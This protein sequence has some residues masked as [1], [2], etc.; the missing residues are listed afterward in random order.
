MKEST[1]VTLGD[2]CTIDAK[3]VDPREAQYALLPHI[4]GENIEA[5]TR[6]LVNV[7]RVGKADLISGK[8]LFSQGDVLYSKLRPYLQ[9]VCVAPERGLC[10]A[11]MY[12][13]R[14]DHHRLVAEY[15]S[16]LLLSPQFTK[17]A[18]TESARARMPKLNRDQLL[19]YRFQLPPLPVQ[20]RIAAKLEAGMGAAARARTAAQVRYAAATALP[21][22]MFRQVFHDI[23]P[24][25]TESSPSASPSRR[26]WKLLTDIARLESGH[27]PS[28][29]HPEW[30]GGDIPWLALPDIRQL[31]GNVAMDTAEHTNQAGLDNSSARLLPENTVALSRTASVG[32]VTIFGKPMATSQDFVNWV[33]GP[34]LR[35]RFLFHA[36]RASRGYLRSLASGAVHK[37]IYMPTVQALRVCVPTLE[38]Q[39]SI[40]SILDSSLRQAEAISKTLDQELE[41]IAAIPATLL[42]LAFK[43]QYGT[44]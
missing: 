43:E 9:K 35:P 29:R 1:T 26:T 17:Y 41:T 5:G 15:L 36:L 33:C 40:V 13:I 12:P 23:L 34:T 19:S 24:I 18:V 11:D 37:T 4:N 21:S 6:R 8:Y 28:R 32:F 7:T 10:S 42:G 31:D 30:W 20:Q 44:R 14:A 25:S 16:W 38:E 3:Q 2:V 39:D 22:A 27:T